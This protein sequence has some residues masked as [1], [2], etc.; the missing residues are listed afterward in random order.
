MNA[1]TFNSQVF[2]N[3]IEAACALA[4]PFVSDVQSNT[5]DEY[6]YAVYSAEEMQQH[7]LI[8]DLVWANGGPIVGFDTTNQNF[9]AAT[10]CSG[11]VARVLHVTKPSAMGV[12]VYTSLVTDVNGKLINFKTDNHPQPFPSAE[13][14]AEWITSGVKHSLQA[15]TFS[16]KA[17]QFSKMGSFSEVIPGDILAYS[18]PAGS[19]DTGHVM[20]INKI[21]QLQKGELNQEL[22]AS[23]LTEFTGTDLLFYAV[24]VYDSSNVAHHNDLRGNGTPKP[25]GVGLGTVLIVADVSGAPIG[26]MFAAHDLLLA[27]VPIPIALDNTTVSAIEAIAVGRPQI[28]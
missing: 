17:T 1:T 23:D 22:W 5:T 28:L 2:S 4:R 13:D 19:N 6:S 20:V 10:D 3:S 18:L 11:F 25:T 24:S 15:V 12:S 26:F 8:N 14:Y 7:F 27:V 16:M 9:V 21:E